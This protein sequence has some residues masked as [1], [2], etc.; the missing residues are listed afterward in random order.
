MNDAE[1]WDYRL[2]PRA[3]DD[4]RALDADIAERIVHKLDDV[5]SSE[6]RAPPDW[7]EPLQGTEYQKPVIGDY[8]TLLLVRYIEHM[9]EVHHVGDR[10]NIY[11]RVL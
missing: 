5:V 4:L 7:L 1:D 11:D 8:R 6:F 9:L 10:R 3:R 2:T